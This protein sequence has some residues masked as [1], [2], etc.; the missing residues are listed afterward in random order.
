[1]Y[2]VERNPCFRRAFMWGIGVGAA[3]GVHSA[4]RHRS[5]AKAI[6]ASVGTFL[7][8]STGMWIY[9]RTAQKEEETRMRDIV[10]KLAMKQAQ[11][12]EHPATP[13]AAKPASK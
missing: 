3:M 6:N 9:C 2:A 13:A 4:I 7:L 10:G 1:M 12:A 5:Q 8:V 11:Q